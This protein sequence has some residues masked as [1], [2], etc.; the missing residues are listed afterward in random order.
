M[1]PLGLGCDQGWREYEGSCYFFSTEPKTWKEANAYCLHRRSNLMSIQDVNERLWLRTQINSEIYWIGLNDQA[2]EGVYEWSDGTTFI[3]YFSYWMQG[4]PDNYGDEPGEDCVQVVGYNF[5]QWNDEHCNV[6]RKFICKHANPNPVPKCD[7]ASGWMQHNSNC[8]KLNS[9]TRKS[10]TAARADC[11]LDGGDLVSIASEAENQYVMAMMGEGH[12]DL[13]IGLSTLKCTKISCQVEAGNSDLSWSDSQPVSYTHW[14]QGQPQ[15]DAQVGSCAAIVK[16]ASDSFGNWTSHQCRF[17][18]PY[19]CKRPL[20]TICPDGWQS[21][22]GSC[23]WMVS[24]RNMMTTWPEAF[25]KC[26]DLGAHLLII[27]SQEE[28]FYINSYLP[29]LNYKDI[30]DM[31]IGLSDKDK[32]GTF[33]WVDKSK[34]TFSNYGPGWPRNTANFWDCG[35]I[36]TGNYAGKWETTNCFKKL[37]YICEMTGGQNPKPTAAPDFHCDSGYLLY[38]NFC[39]FFKIEDVKNWANAEAECVKEQ[40]HLASFHSEEEFS[41]LIAH[42]PG[43]AWVGL[44]DRTTEGHFVFTDGTQADF[45][46]WGKGQPDIYEDEDCVHVQGTG[47]L[48][49]GKLNDDSCTSRKDYICKKGWNEKCGSWMSD[50]YNDY[51]YLF[52]YYSM[53]TWAEARADCVNQGGDLV[54][55]TD[56]FEQAFIQ[57]VIQQSPTGVS[58][59]MGGFHSTN[60]GGWEW[61]DGSPFRYVHWNAGD[62]DNYD[63]EDCLSILINNGYWNDDKCERNRGYI[64]KRRG[65]TPKP[66]LPHDELRCPG[67]DW[68]EFGEFCYKPF[69]ERKTW[70]GARQACRAQGA[71]LVSVLSMAEQNWLESYL[72]MAT[73]D[74]WTGLNDLAFSGL[75]M[76]SDEHLTTFTYWAPGE[77]N[78]HEG[79]QD[80]CVEMSHQTGRWN[81]VAC[82]ELNSYICKQAKAHYPVP[83]VRPT[84]Y[85]CPQGWDAYAYACYW[86]EETARSWTEAK[87]FCMEKEGF[88]VHVGDIYE[89]A[90]FTVALSLRTGFW[91]MGLRAQ[92]GGGGGGGGVDYVWDNGSPVT[93]THWDR[94][95]PDSGDGTCVAMTAGSAGGFWDDRQCSKK[96]A[97]ICEKPRPDIGPPTA[98]PT[99]PPAQGCAAGWTA[100]PHF[101]NCYKLFHNVDWSQK[102]SWGAARNDC[103]CRGG[104]LV[105]IHSQEEEEFLSTYS[106]GTSKWIGL[107]HYPTEGGY[108]W[109]DGTPLSHTNWADGEPNNHEGREECVEMVSSP[110]GTYSWWNDLNCDAHQD[111]ICKIVKGKEP[112]EP[113]VAPTPLPALECGSNP[114]W[115]KYNGICYY[116]NDTDMVD[117]HTAVLR[118]YAEKALLV[119][120][121]NQHEQAY[122]NRMVG[123]GKV[124]AAWIGLRKFGVASGQYLY[125][126]LMEGSSTNTEETT[127]SCESSTPY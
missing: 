30:P 78:N 64:C 74:M 83:S 17:E 54:S 47:Q 107:Q 6:S 19:M 2:V 7:L 38:G 90:H 72:D 99:P 77:P 104:A 3:P 76:W 112:V 25:T 114:G 65:N 60:E 46:P 88:L 121:L 120:I 1:G 105:S 39:Y 125:V 50:P 44:N 109:S 49:P 9:D 24:N 79:L 92:G 110:S 123:T 100:L 124:S 22:S 94:D 126:S 52:N 43:E 98:G 108:S 113:R 41:F 33:Q 48:D 4:Q 84:V 5:G 21:F 15:I 18:R 96:F 119:S 45:L 12:I 73:S 69:S 81:D 27:N 89:Q 37:G 29:H 66:P 70:H 57:G 68:Y 62:P 63:G 40:G 67:N 56:P 36:F 118:C 111:W 8:Y 51:C 34:V 23:Y 59:W 80:G 95:Q 16:D 55:I 20:S 26:S 11:V 28:Q 35:Q 58:L 75:F 91:W 117:F 103:F 86:M 127:N 85:G 10:W 93:F 71:E 42:M 115:R 31:W 32:D 97:F 61:I 87:A 102:K 13:W 116:Y 53:R 122:V 14:A 101:R 82:T 106:K